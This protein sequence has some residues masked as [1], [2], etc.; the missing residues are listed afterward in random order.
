MDTKTHSIQEVAEATR[1]TEHTLRY[2][3]RIGLI[4]CIRREDN[5]HRRYTSDDLGWIDFLTKLRATGMSITDMLHYA[6]LQRAGDE[7][8]PERLEMLKTL[9]NNLESQIGTLQEHLKVI[10]YKVE[11]Y[12]EVV[13]SMKQKV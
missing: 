11:Y 3:E 12:T 8:L 9:R 7:T 5:G 6:E 13:E 10:R 1:L 4:Q 2:Y